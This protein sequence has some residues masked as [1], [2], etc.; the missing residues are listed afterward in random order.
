MRKKKLVTVERRRRKGDF[1][2]VQRAEMN[3]KKWIVPKAPRVLTHISRSYTAARPDLI[4]GRRSAPINENRIAKAVM[5]KRE[6]KLNL[7]C[8]GKEKQKMKKKKKTSSA[9]SPVNLRKPLSFSYSFPRI[10]CSTE[11][12]P[13]SVADIMLI[14]VQMSTLTSLHDVI[15]PQRE[16]ERALRDGFTLARP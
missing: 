9:L 13:P 11:R 12:P 8:A 2:K 6:E 15:Q 4:P 7:L 14:A 16:R 10:K 3:P 5:Q 1:A